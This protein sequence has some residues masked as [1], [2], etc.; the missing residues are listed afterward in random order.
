MF[1]TFIMDLRKKA[2][3]KGIALTYMKNGKRVR[4]T[5]KQLRYHMRL[6][7]SAFGSDTGAAEEKPAKSRPT[8]EQTREKRERGRMEREE[9]LTR[10]HDIIAD[11]EA[12]RSLETIVTALEK[13]DPRGDADR[14]KIDDTL[15]MV[16]TGWGDAT[17]GVRPK[18]RVI[19]NAEYI[20]EKLFPILGK[21]RI[22]EMVL[23]NIGQNSSCGVNI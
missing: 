2:K 13:Q 7:R 11:K 10:R 14:K 15:K 18:F 4:K 22:F 12:A 17:L 3:K 5:D 1:V 19:E 8:K 21:E 6:R 16:L 9:D 20:L 23:L